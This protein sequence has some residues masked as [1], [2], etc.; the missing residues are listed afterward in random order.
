[1]KGTPLCHITTF[2]K[3]FQMRIFCMLLCFSIAGTAQN[4]GTFEELGGGVRG[5]RIVEHGTQTACKHDKAWPLCSDDEWGAKCPSGCRMQGLI[6]EMD[7]EFN[8]R[9]NKIKTLLLDNQNSYKRSSVLKEEIS[10]VLERN[11]ISEQQIDGSYNEISDDLRR[12]LVILKERVVEQVKRIRVLQK[13]IQNQVGE[14]RRLEVDV[15]IKV[16]ACKGSCAR[17]F[18]Y[19][20]D[21]ESYA[22]IQMQLTQSNSIN[23]QPPIQDKPL[24]VLKMRPLKDS[25]VPSHFKT[26]PLSEQEMNVLNH[27]TIMVATLEDSGAGSRTSPSVTKQVVPGAEAGEYSKGVTTTQRGGSDLKIVR[28]GSPAGV[29]CIRTVTKKRIQSAGGI[30]EEVMEEYKTPDGSDCSHLKGLVSEAGG[31]HHVKV[32]SSGGGGS[33]LPDFS[34]LGSSAR[35]F[36]NFGSGSK[37]TEATDHTPSF[38]GSETSFDLTEGEDDDFSRLDHASSS[39]SKTSHDSKFV[40]IG[41]THINGFNKGGST[42]E[43]KSVKLPFRE[44][45]G[46]QHDESGEDTPDYRARSSST[47][48]EKLG[49]SYIG[50]DCEDI[51]QKHTS[52]AQSGIFRI[53]PSGSAQFFSVYCD[54][55]TT[56]GGWL[57][58]QQRL[59]GSLNFN[60]TWEDYKKGFGSVDGS[61]KGELWLGNE[62]LYLLTEKDTVLRVEV[63]DWEGNEAYAEYFIHIGSESEGYKLTISDYEGTAGDALIRG[64]EEEGSEY[65]AHANM[66]FST[67]DRD[68]DQWEE[69]CAEVYGGGWWYNNCQAANLNGI[70]YQG[71][72]YDP[73]NNVP[74]EIENGVVWVPFKPSDYSLKVVRMKIRPV[75][76]D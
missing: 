41:N 42:L 56:L 66:K 47:G 75:E 2:L 8:D 53:K 11:L 48:G 43:F 39:S 73:R 35:E 34:S 29:T 10:T 16:R 4:G 21:R 5:P 37:L 63:E 20:D 32:T 71:G 62:N 46:V 14:L 6:D 45:E 51:H 23:F 67:F 49:E 59:D 28:P 24:K 9:I 76:T 44:V 57:L 18:N 22:N 13:T 60:R 30:R 3:M 72:Q 40:V 25:T 17:A 58:V 61:G 74:Y 7:Q 31:T 36:F 64:S 27:I 38:H 50:T 68:H 1:M 69:N 33:G 54:Q 52:G 65:T 26:S 70:Y 12:R 19:V 55:E 15:D